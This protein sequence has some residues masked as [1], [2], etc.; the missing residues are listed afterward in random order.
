M[1][2]NEIVVG[3]KVKTHDGLTG[4]VKTIP[5]GVRDR[6]EVECDGD[7][8]SRTYSAFQLEVN[9]ATPKTGDDA[10]PI[11]TGDRV[12]TPDGPGR[13]VRS[14]G[15][16][17]RLVHVVKLDSG[18]EREYRAAA[19]KLTPVKVGRFGTL[20]ET[21]AF[22]VRTKTESAENAIS[23][24]K[25]SVQSGPSYAMKWLGQQAAEAEET[26]ARFRPLNDA[27]KLDTMT[28]V[29]LVAGITQEINEVV[30]RVLRWKPNSSTC[31]WS[32]AVEDAQHMGYRDYGR[33]LEEILATYLG[34]GYT[35][36]LPRF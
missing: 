28:D 5:V 4:R 1:K 29:E 23:K 17:E 10:A 35:R 27:A 9:S 11:V 16:S 31:R 30:D 8:K 7:G 3:M 24:F 36:K 20:R 25:T 12:N 26:L 33:T 21:I 32:N 14:V 22:Y 15:G 34:D 19:G 18:D 13:I 2:K 6:L